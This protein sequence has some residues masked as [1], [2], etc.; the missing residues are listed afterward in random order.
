MTDIISMFL[1]TSVNIFKGN[2]NLNMKTVCKDNALNAQYIN[3]W[4]EDDVEGIQI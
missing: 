1:Q 2:I 4:N 3:E